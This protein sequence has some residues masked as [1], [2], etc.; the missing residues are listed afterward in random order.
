VAVTRAKVGF[1]F[2]RMC[3]SKFWKA[4]ILLH[5]SFIGSLS[6]WVKADED[7]SHKKWSNRDSLKYDVNYFSVP[8]YWLDNHCKT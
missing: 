3:W 1:C 5:W 7:T 4:Y 8:D 6:R 2:N